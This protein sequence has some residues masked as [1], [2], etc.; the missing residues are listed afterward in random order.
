MLNATHAAEQ[1]SGVEQRVGAGRRQ[2]G[3]LMP[4]PLFAFFACGNGTKGHP[5]SILF[6]SFLT[7]HNPSLSF[8]SYR[9]LLGPARTNPLTLRHFHFTFKLRHFTMKLS[10]SL[11]LFAIFPLALAAPMCS[12]KKPASAT[13]TGTPTGEAPAPTS[14]STGNSPSGGGNGSRISMGWFANWHDNF[15][16][17]DI[18]WKGYNT[19][20]FFTSD[21]YLFRL[22]LS[23]ITLF[24]VLNPMII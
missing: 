7:P 20:A 22:H 15:T 14:T 23:L 1:W 12:L 9:F 6:S 21:H 2:C 8:L 5:L 10:T 4:I 3:C 19:M 11:S 17:S 24:L 18:N 13:P 16:V